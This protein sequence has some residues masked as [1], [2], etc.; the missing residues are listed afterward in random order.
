MTR[1]DVE[2]IAETIRALPGHSA[3]LRAHQASTARAFADALATTNP[4][5]DRVSFLKACGLEN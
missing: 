2:L 1:K 4:D 3:G 5:F